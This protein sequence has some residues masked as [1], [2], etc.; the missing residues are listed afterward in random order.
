[1]EERDKQDCVGWRSLQ[2]N[3]NLLAKP[4]SSW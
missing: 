3:V 2:I 1:M 4:L